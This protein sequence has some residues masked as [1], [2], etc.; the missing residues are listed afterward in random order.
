MVNSLSSFIS[1]D[2][3]QHMCN[4]LVLYLWFGSRFAGSCI[5]SH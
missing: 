1:W 2:H 4:W 5:V 3:E